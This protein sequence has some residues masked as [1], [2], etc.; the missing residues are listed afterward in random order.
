MIIFIFESKEMQNKPLLILQARTGSKRL[1]NKMTLDFH[2]GLTIPQIIINNLKNIFEPNQIVLATSTKK[3]DDAL[4]FLANEEGVLLFRGAE[5]DVLQRFIDC[6]TLFK[7]KKIVRICSDNP[8]L[9]P[10]YIPPLLEKLQNENLEYT[11]YQWKDGT[12]IMLSHIGIFA[13]AMTIDFLK[14]IKSST[15]DSKYLEHV[16]NYIYY[17]N[18]QFKYAFLPL[19]EFLEDRQNVRLTVDTESDFLIAQELYDN[20]YIKKNSFKLEDLLKLIDENDVI[21]SNMEAQI[22]GNAK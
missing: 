22:K 16:T 2:K 20:I 17:N 18:K 1:P 3:E 9:R 19:P 4:E 14:K 15:D 8:F 10:E 13:E 21:K 12:P 5:N 11:S 7:A 6:A